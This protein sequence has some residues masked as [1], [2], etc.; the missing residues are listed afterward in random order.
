MEKIIIIG[1]G[2][3]AHSVVDSI[4]NNELFEIAGFIGP[5]LDETFSYHGYNIIGTDDDLEQI[6]QQG[7]KNAF[8]AIGFLGEGNLREKIYQQLKNIGYNIPSI[9]DKTAVVSDSACIGEG[10]FVGKNAVVNIGAI[11]EKM[12]IINTNA[13]VEHDTKVGAF[14]HVAVSTVLC[15][16]VVIGKSSLIGANATVLQCKKVGNNVIVGAG[17]IVTK[18][19]NDKMRWIKDMLLSKEGM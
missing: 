14:S 1:S 17:S 13:I 2:G 8:V 5:D 10:V 4:E 19:I 7:I 16:E 18:N 12:A 9:I 3:H 11:I 15:G 6:Y